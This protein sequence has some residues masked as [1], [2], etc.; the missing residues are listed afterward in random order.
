MKQCQFPFKFDGE[1]FH[2]CID[3]IKNPGGRVSV[4][5]WCSTKVDPTTRQHITGGGFFGD[6]EAS[7]PSDEEAKTALV[8]GNFLS[9]PSPEEVLSII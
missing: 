3:S 9:R 4:D 1:E 7:C 2:G 5:P 8:K 6:C